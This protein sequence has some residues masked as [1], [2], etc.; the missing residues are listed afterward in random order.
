ML[1]LPTL[2]SYQPSHDKHFSEFE[3]E[4]DGMSDSLIYP[5][6]TSE[7]PHRNEVET[8]SFN[9]G[10]KSRLREAVGSPMAQKI[11]DMQKSM[12]ENRQNSNFMLVSEASASQVA[13]AFLT[14][15]SVRL[16][17]RFLGR[18]GN[19][20]VFEVTRLFNDI[21]KENEK[22]ALKL[23]IK[24][25]SNGILLDEIPTEE[26]RDLNF[27]VK[28][29]TVKIGDVN[30]NCDVLPLAESDLNKFNLSKVQDPIQCLLNHIKNAAQGAAVLHNKDILHRDIKPDNILVLEE[31]KRAQLGDLD[32]ISKIRQVEHVTTC[33]PHFAHPSIWGNDVIKQAERY[34]I[35]TKA[36]DA[37]ALGRT[38]QYGL[39]ARI[40]KRYEC[41]KPSADRMQPTSIQNLENEEAVSEVINQLNLSN[42]VPVVTRM[43]TIQDK[44]LPQELL[45]YPS[46]F[47]LN[48]ENQIGLDV[49]KGEL[50]TNEYKALE[51]AIHL[52]NL[53]Q[54]DN[55]AERPSIEDIV[56]RIEEF[57]NT[58]NDADLD[59]SVS[60]ALH[61]EKR[62]LEETKESSQR[63]KR[64]R[65]STQ[66]LNIRS[67]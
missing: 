42:K 28:S 8:T 2:H 57:Q 47:D 23:S 46:I 35:Q 53:L 26:K 65:R 7:F 25:R 55:P 61:T 1:T 29:Y 64:T 30:K 24:K 60:A 12:Q 6:H 37:F 67:K 59:L 45:I 27:P 32:N 66:D 22:E 11:V 3:T 4:I 17:T 41:A 44:T 16:Q 38:I 13:R 54:H 56:R 58:L 33:T 40:F 15:D 20:E 5:N 19:G 50:K 14:P 51:L 9:N 62:A 34:G 39:I 48:K 18:G 36:D 31:G 10:L 43:Q 21:T 52:A 63:A 49:L